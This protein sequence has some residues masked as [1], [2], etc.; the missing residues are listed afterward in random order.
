MWLVV[1]PSHAAGF[2]LLYF[3]VFHLVRTELVDMHSA[4]SEALVREAISDLRPAMDH[5]DRAQFDELLRR[6]IV[7]HGLTD[8]R[9]VA[10]PLSDAVLESVEDIE[11][12][13]RSGEAARVRFEKVGDQS[14]IRGLVRVDSGVQCAECHGERN[15][16]AVAVVVR[17]VTGQVS[18]LDTGLRW[19]MM[20]LIAG[21]GLM[22]I[23]SGIVLR[24]GARQ[25]AAL[26]EADL[27]A[28]ENGTTGRPGQPSS[29]RLDPVTEELHRSLRRFLARQQER[30]EV[31]ATRLQR[32][33]S[34]GSLGQVAAGLAHE[35]KNPVAGLQGALEVLRDGCDEEETR[36]VYGQMLAE[37]Q[38]IN[39][40][41][42]SLLD[43]SRPA[44]PNPAPTDIARLAD[45]T[46]QLMR[47]ALSRQGISIELQTSADAPTAFVDAKQIRQALVNLLTN[48]A[49]ALGQGGTVVVRV[50][51]LTPGSGV[52]VAVEDDGPGIPEE[53]IER[54]FEPFHST[55]A[56]GTGLGLA[57]TRTLV[58]QNGG[59]VEV[60]SVLG[61][62]STFYV[63][64]PRAEAADA[65]AETEER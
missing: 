58:R 56:A 28:V 26:V 65:P 2:L 45:D 15:P 29:L 22:V 37:L 6:F 55:K 42:Q 39:E 30:R 59:E 19:T 50:A 16:I 34:L 7:E 20:L 13:L 5:Q 41:I 21:W 62:G 23:T 36:A 24:H 46:I 1:V 60:E 63:I 51:P 54:I 9:L 4:G 14:V 8:V 31:E 10:L 40:T 25:S 49:E 64:L 33:E 38:R 43:L 32:A 52:V 61:S 11:D 18:D 53:E 35:I 57:I 47:P 3:A 12:F 44:E 17:D 48:A 27:R